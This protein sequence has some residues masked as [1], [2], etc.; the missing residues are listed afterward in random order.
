[1]TQPF[2]RFFLS[3]FLSKSKCG[4]KKELKQKLQSSFTATL[5]VEGKKELEG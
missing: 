1:M 4:R 3:F 2:P 5:D